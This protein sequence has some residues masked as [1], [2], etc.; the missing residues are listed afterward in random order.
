MTICNMA[1]ECGARGAIVAPDDKALA[2]LEPKVRMAAEA[3]AAAT[4]DWGKLRS[5][6]DAAF[7]RTI[8]IDGDLIE[9]MVTWGT[10]PDQALPIGDV[11]PDPA[12]QA[13]PDRRDD[14]ERSLAYMG[15]TP[16]ARLDAVPIDRAFIGSCTNA[17]IEDL[18]EAA[19][20]LRGR[21]I[22]DTVRGMVV[23]GSSAVKRQAETEGL[24]Q[25]FIAAGFEWRQSG[26][27]MCL[28]MNDDVLAPGDA[29]RI[30]AFEADHFSRRPWLQT[31][32]PVDART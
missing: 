24:D 10:S 2:Y 8:A 18:R 13:D 3:W 11:V 7:D 16:G 30:R 22:A 17:R 20:L 23:P 1:V 29:D 4:A 12:A 25:V 31:P 32:E 26:C 6:V 5:D 28:A 9:P 27:S 19:D 14:M 15:L 21:R